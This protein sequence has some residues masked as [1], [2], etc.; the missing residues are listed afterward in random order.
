MLAIDLITVSEIAPTWKD[1][2]CK[3]SGRIYIF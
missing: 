1:V 2:N 3:A